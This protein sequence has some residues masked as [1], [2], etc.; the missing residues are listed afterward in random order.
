MGE[1]Q[2]LKIIEGDIM[3]NVLGYAN[4]MIFVYLKTNDI[5]DSAFATSR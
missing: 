1:N 2:A 5:F 4:C 3:G